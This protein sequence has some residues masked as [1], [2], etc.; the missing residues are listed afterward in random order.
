MIDKKR[1]G[2]DEHFSDTLEVHIEYNLDEDNSI[3][4]RVEFNKKDVVESL[5]NEV[6]KLRRKVRELEKNRRKQQV[7]GK[8]VVEL[9]D[10]EEDEIWNEY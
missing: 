8:A 9:W 7:S 10:N 3:E 1:T 5:V 6:S 4:K 2:S